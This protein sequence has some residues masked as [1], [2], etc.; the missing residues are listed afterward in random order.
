M[1]VSFKPAHYSKWF[2]HVQS[3]ERT[4]LLA[5][6]QEVGLSTCVQSTF[7]LLLS[8]TALHDHVVKLAHSIGQQAVVSRRS[9]LIPFA[10]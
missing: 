8:S 2:V 5:L 10:C 7:P 1:A 4:A 3:E 6:K 9:A